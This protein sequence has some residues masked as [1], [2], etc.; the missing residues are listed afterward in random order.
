MQTTNQKA[1][2]RTRV[3]IGINALYP[4]SANRSALIPLWL[5]AGRRVDQE[6]YLYYR[7]TKRFTNEKYVREVQLVT[8]IGQ[9][10]QKLSL[11]NCLNSL[12]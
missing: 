6:T 11:S 5:W 10:L 1:V 9:E 8:L 12:I 7:C 2:I 3:V 4:S